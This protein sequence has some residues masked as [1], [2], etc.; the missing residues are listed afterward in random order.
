MTTALTRL[1]PA[2][3]ATA[4]SSARPPTRQLLRSDEVHKFTLPAWALPRCSSRSSHASYCHWLPTQSESAMG[5][6]FL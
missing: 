1:Y 4:S 6:T 5:A 3:H 2:W